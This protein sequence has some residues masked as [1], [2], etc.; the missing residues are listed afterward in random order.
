MY[1]VSSYHLFVCLFCCF[2]SQ[3]NSYG[4]GGTVSSPNTFFP[5]QAWTS[6]LPVLCAH[7]FACSWEWFSGR[8][9]NDPRN[10]FMINL[11][12]YGTGPGSNLRP[13][14]QQSASHLLPD[15][16]PTALCGP[17]SSYHNQIFWL[18]CRCSWIIHI[19]AWAPFWI[20]VDF[21]MKRRKNCR[22]WG[23]VYIYC[24]PLLYSLFP[25]YSWNG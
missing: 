15:T 7:A 19:C 20:A 17:I 4:H 2:T 22:K 13:Q 16:L 3:V 25:H 18:T 23:L 24:R 8:E 9:E 11:Q 21:L 12:K 6:S 5:G 14:D 10:Y 1:L